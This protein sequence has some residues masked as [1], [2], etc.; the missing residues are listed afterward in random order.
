M[1]ATN[2]GK[3]AF[4][5]PSTVTNADGDLIVMSRNMQ[6][7]IVD[8]EGKEESVL[9]HKL[10]M[11]AASPYARGL[12]TGKWVEGNAS[13]NANADEAS[14]KQTAGCMKVTLGKENM[15]DILSLRAAV[16]YI[17]T[18]EV[19]VA[20]GRLPMM[21]RTAD[22]LG[23]ERLH[24][25]CLAAM[26]QGLDDSNALWLRAESI[27]TLDTIDD[28]IAGRLHGGAVGG[29]DVPLEICVCNTQYSTHRG[30]HW[31]VV[32]YSIRRKRAEEQ[33]CS[34]DPMADCM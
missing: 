5:N 17:Y 30:Y 22:Y 15:V 3:I 14:C 27:S 4:T 29:H 1:E 33:D 11:V 20:F 21:A 28:R 25:T 7:C 9:V 13:N 6:V 10:V 8:G 2:E 24:G 23:L 18:G 16:E 26:K 12:L 34:D 31:F 19:R 32:A